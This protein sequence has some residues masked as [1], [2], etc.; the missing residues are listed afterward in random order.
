MK[1]I[2]TILECEK[3]EEF[4]YDLQCVGLLPIDFGNNCHKKLNCDQTTPLIVGGT[5]ARKHEFPHF[6]LLGYQISPDDLSFHCGGSLISE[7][8]VLTA[9][10]CQISQ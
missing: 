3:Y 9:A 10:H 1:L 7:S 8:F 4:S 5:E 6:A 2:L